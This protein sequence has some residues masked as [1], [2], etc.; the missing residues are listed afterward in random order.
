VPD[1]IKMAFE[2]GRVVGSLSVQTDA[3][4]GD[5]PERGPDRSGAAASA[6]TRSRARSKRSPGSK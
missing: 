6:N 2:D 3:D 4:N 1:L 5:G